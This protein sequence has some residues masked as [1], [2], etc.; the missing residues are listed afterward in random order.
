[1]W[2]MLSVGNASLMVL[3][4]KEYF[5]RHLGPQVNP[6]TGESWSSLGVYDFFVPRIYRIQFPEQFSGGK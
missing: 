3:Y 6:L 1:M 4:C 5:T 2:L